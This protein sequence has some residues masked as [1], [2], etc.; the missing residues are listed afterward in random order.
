MTQPARRGFLVRFDRIVIDKWGVLPPAEHE[1][2]AHAELCAYM[3]SLRLKKSLKDAAKKSS[4]AGS[5]R[6]A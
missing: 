4:K 1:R 2:R 3:A 5:N 6:A